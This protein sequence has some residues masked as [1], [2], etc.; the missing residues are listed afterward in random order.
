MKLYTTQL[1]IWKCLVTGVEMREM[2]MR[3]LVVGANM[4]KYGVAKDC[5]KNPGMSRCGADARN[6]GCCPPAWELSAWNCTETEF[7][8]TA[9]KLT[10][11]RWVLG[12]ALGTALKLAVSEASDELHYLLCCPVGYYQLLQQNRKYYQTRVSNCNLIILGVIWI[13]VTRCLARANKNSGRSK[14][15]NKFYKKRPQIERSLMLN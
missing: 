7:C 14:I 3:L 10:G 4:T 13:F 2:S 9:L 12:S 1:W 5:V 6:G 11:L 15:F 8:C